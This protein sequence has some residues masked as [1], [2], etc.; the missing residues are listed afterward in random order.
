MSLIIQRIRLENVRGIGEVEIEIP[1]NGVT[2]IEAPNES[3]KS[4]LFDA[5]DILFD[6]KSSSGAAKVKALQPVGK[7]VGSRIEADLIIGPYLLTYAKQFNRDKKTELTIHSPQR[8]QL[9]GDD[10]HNRVE[11]LLD[12]HVDTV[13][14]K[15]LWIQ[16]GRGLDV[17]ELDRSTAVARALGSNPDDDANAGNVDRSSE[18]DETDESLLDRVEQEFLKYFTKT[19]QPNKAMKET[20]E[21]VTAA[22]AA[23][24]TLKERVADIDSLA[25]EQSSVIAEIQRSN[26]DIQHAQTSKEE[27][28]TRLA[29]V[30]DHRATLDRIVAEAAIATERLSMLKQREQLRVEWETSA[31]ALQNTLADLGDRVTTQ[32]T[33]VADLETRAEAR[34]L[35]R[36]HFELVL[37]KAEDERERAERTVSFITTQREYETLRDRLSQIDKAQRALNEAQAALDGN[38]VSPEHV[39]AIQSALESLSVVEAQLNMAAPSVKITAL[40]D[41][42][43]DINGQ[44][45]TLTTGETHESPVAGQVTINIAEL[46]SIDVTSGSS[47]NELT[48][49]VA[50]AKERRDTALRAAKVSSLAD[51]E[52]ALEQRRTAESDKKAAE[53]LVATLLDGSSRETLFDESLKLQ[54]TANRIAEE[55]LDT[56]DAN[57]VDESSAR[58]RLDAAT[59]AERDATAALRKVQQQ[60]DGIND[61]LARERTQLAGI[62]TERAATQ[63]QLD[64]IGDSQDR[65]RNELS[66][67]DLNGLVTTQEETLTA[68]TSDQSA[69][70][71]LLAQLDATA[72]EVLHENAVRRLQDAQTRITDLQTR[73]TQISTSLE[74]LGGTGLGE[75]LADAEAILERVTQKERQTRGRANAVKL[76]KQNLESA[77]SE[78]FDSYRAP[79]TERINALGRVVFDPTFEV[80]IDDAFEITK[81]TMKGNTLTR[82]AL[83]SGAQEQLSVLTAV[84]AAQLAS[85]GGVPLVLDDTL[86]FSDP[87]RM[88][89]VGAVLSRVDDAQVI[90]LTCVPARFETIGGANR[91]SLLQ[92]LRDRIG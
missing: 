52:L 51:A 55:G 19:G 48:T 25:V 78:V 87:D 39:K 81:R 85:D 72:V 91:I 70:E 67:E 49:A 10:A 7:D 61:E 33:V 11:Q 43:T 56:L 66:D 73:E 3:G 29:E 79:L 36:A 90:V 88:E 16:Q 5:V 30:K 75:E 9:T 71:Q 21:A 46:V 64:Q 37:Q 80:E 69:V 58:E 40:N 68:L 20:V 31:A 17:I 18:G 77:R 41:L 13:L 24:H 6:L 2:V 74:V 86:G 82:E 1:S 59:E 23:V 14:L 62:T 54:A 34:K 28:E 15:S 38:H 12:M 57:E 83:S 65:A 32:S 76:L 84:A 63:S 53:Q 60:L 26:Q 47:L 50:I 44:A 42:Q 92:A 35:E 45:V 8:E 27:L 89:R 4:T 22:H